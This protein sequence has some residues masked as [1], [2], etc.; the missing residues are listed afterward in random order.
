MDFTLQPIDC[1]LQQHNHEDE[2][3]KVSQLSVNNSDSEDSPPTDSLRSIKSRAE[4]KRQQQRLLMSAGKQQSFTSAASS[5]VTSSKVRRDL[6]RVL[7]VNGS[8]SGK[9]TNGKSSTGRRK[10]LSSN[11]HSNL[12]ND[13]PRKRKL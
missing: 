7:G 13:V 8:S 3:E 2:V 6:S 10:S 11:L 9:N 5:G 1:L 4:E 12:K